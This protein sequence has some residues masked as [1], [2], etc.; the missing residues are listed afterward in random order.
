MKTG[1]RTRSIFK[2]VVRPADSTSHTEKFEKFLSYL[3]LL[4]SYT[5]GFTQG[6]TCRVYARH[7]HFKYAP[8]FRVQHLRYDDVTSKPNKGRFECLSTPELFEGPSM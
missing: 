7:T 5:A 8:M 6:F 2:F 4:T 1:G 3:Q